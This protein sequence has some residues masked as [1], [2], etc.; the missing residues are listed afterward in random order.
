[1]PLDRSSIGYPCCVLSRY[2]RLYEM[3]HVCPRDPRNLLLGRHNPTEPAELLESS[4]IAFVCCARTL[5]LC[6]QSV[7]DCP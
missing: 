3:N 1:M 6:L 4:C 2:C 5:Q 7:P